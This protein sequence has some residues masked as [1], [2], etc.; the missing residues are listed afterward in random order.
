MSVQKHRVNV[1]HRHKQPIATRKN[2]AHTERARHHRKYRHNT[3]ISTHQSS[4][5]TLI[6]VRHALQQIQTNNYQ[7]RIEIEERRFCIFPIN[8]A[9]SASFQH[10]SSFGRSSRY[11]SQHE[12]L[13]PYAW[14]VHANVSS[15]HASWMVVV[16]FPLS[17]SHGV[18]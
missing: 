11:L 7:T 5:R 3:H 10:T 2:Q 14:H 15:W 16:C 8:Y 6:R 1:P 18:Y 12:L 4:T 9:S 17:V 13:P